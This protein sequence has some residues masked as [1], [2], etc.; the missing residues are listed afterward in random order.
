[1]GTKPA[2]P[3]SLRTSAP[4]ISGKLLEVVPNADGP[5]AM[6]TGSGRS[7]TDTQP[8]TVRSVKQRCLRAVESDCSC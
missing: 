4:A 7:S 3:S 5:V 1:M 6:L 8:R 2:F